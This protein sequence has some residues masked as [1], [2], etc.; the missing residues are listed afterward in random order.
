MEGDKRFP[1][2]SQASEYEIREGREIERESPS[3]FHDRVMLKFAYNFGASSS[4]S[5]ST[6]PRAIARVPDF[7]SG[8]SEIYD[9]LTGRYDFL[10]AAMLSTGASR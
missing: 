1:R 5:C 4:G 6:N 2:M 7:F 10:S 3:R 9:L 8:E